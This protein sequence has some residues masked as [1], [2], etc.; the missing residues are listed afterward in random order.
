MR[1]C[2]NREVL[3]HDEKAYEMWGDLPKRLLC[4]MISANGDFLNFTAQLKVFVE[5][6]LVRTI[7]DVFDEDAS[8]IRVISGLALTGTLLRP[9]DLTFFALAYD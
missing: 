8:L 5:L 9:F 3:F 6:C 4:V 1:I 7:V 2:K